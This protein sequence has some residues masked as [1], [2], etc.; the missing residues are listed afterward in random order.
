MID[1]VVIDGVAILRGAIGTYHHKQCAQA[2]VM[3]IEGV[4]MV[5]N[6]IKVG[7]RI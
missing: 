5:E 1:C 4:R 7:P 2:L 6:L 3:R